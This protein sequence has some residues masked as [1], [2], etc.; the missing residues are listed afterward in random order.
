MNC[1]V[2]IIATQIVSWKWT[3]IMHYLLLKLTPPQWN[4]KRF[5]S[6]TNFYT[7]FLSECCYPSKQN[8]IIWYIY[9]YI[10]IYT[11]SK[12]QINKK[13][14]S[15]LISLHNVTKSAGNL[16]IWLQFTEEILNRKLH[17]SAQWLIDLLTKNSISDLNLP[18][19]A[20]NIA[21]QITFFSKAS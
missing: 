11:I 20:I 21:S 13:C 5:T 1:H 15:L 19:K 18:N 14:A 7:T 10:Y 2:I 12:V 6:S 4:F 17:F 8:K 16:R 9:I 3:S